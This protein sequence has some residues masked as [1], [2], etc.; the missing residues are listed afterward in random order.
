MPLAGEVHLAPDGVRELADHPHRVVDVASRHV[1][2]QKKRDPHQDVDVGLHR[3][4]HPRATHLHH[5]V[6]PADQ[7][8]AVH[9]RD[10]GPGDRVG[11]D[12]E[13]ALGER[14][15]ELLLDLIPDL[16]EGDAGDVVLQVRQFLDERG[17]YDIGA[18]GEELS[19][20]YEG[21]AQLLHGE[22]QALGS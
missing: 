20:L 8:G 14:H 19:Q 5:H 6:L 10:G 13:E 16:L 21:G 18:G 2:L 4:G 12:G 7:P 9:L 1:A 15:P 17:G 3:L 11:I 22:P